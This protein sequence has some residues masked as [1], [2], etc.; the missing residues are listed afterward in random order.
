MILIKEGGEGE[1]RKF[2]SDAS[3]VEVMPESRCLDAIVMNY[4]YILVKPAG[5]A[6]L[7][8]CEDKVC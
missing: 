3:T 5:L 4:L 8:C 6:K 7:N 2:Y 1:K